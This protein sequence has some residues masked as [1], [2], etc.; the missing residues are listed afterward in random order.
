[1]APRAEPDHLQRNGAIETLLMRAI[2]Y[3]LT[4][5][6]D[7]LQQFVVAKVAKYLCPPRDGL[8]VA[9]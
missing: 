3:S 6:A 8:A 5:T 1:V 7:F 9:S 2:N 4:A